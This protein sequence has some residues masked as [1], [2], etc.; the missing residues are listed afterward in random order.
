M[1][2]FSKIQDELIRQIELSKESLKISVTWF[3]NHDLF[4]AILKKLEDP[5]FSI[6]L[7]VLNDRINN[8]RFGVNFQKLI[9]N[10]GHFYY[11]YR[12]NMVH[13]KFC[14]VDNK[15][16][17]TGSYNWTYDAERKN[18]ENIVILDE[19]KIVKGYIDEFEQLKLHHKE[20][21]NVS[22]VCR[23][24]IDINSTDYLQSDYLI[25]A[26]Q[27]ELRGNDLQA[28]KIYTELLRIDNKKTEIISARNEIVEKYNG[29]VFEVSPF[30]IG[31]LY[32]NGYAMVIP[33]F[34]QLPFTGVSV[35]STTTEGAKSLG[36]TIQKN[37][38]IPKTILTFSLANIQ[39][40]PIGT[41][42][43]ELTLTLNKSGLLT[44]IAK[45]L[46]GFNEV[47]DKSVDIKNCL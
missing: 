22:S 15:T 27:E 34:V 33:E 23:T 7:I 26:K 43:V 19:S 29:Q 36:I 39:P 40:S 42:K 38:Y 6:E 18:W 46:N 31:I 45:E 13:H 8:K 28:A 9:D 30:E 47:A 16:I 20:V 14:I 2:L 25:Q 44:V 4:N 32:K 24:D 3:T 5:N 35:G 12:E 41:E 17:I 11:S 37:D 10:N 21:K 1:Q